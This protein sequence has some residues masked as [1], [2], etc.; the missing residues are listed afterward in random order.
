MS[1]PETQA[2][3][4]NPWV[5][6]M[7]PGDIGG[8]NLADE[9]RQGGLPIQIVT[10]SDSISQIRKPRAIIV[11][12]SANSETSE[13]IHTILKTKLQP[14]IPVLASNQSLPSGPWST[15]PVLLGKD[16]VR[17]ILEYLSHWETNSM[18][19]QNTMPRQSFSKS[20]SSTRVPSSAYSTKPA[21]KPMESKGSGSPARPIPPPPPPPVRRGFFAPQSLV[22]IVILLVVVGLVA[23]LIMVARTFLLGGSDVTNYSASVPGPTCDND[24]HW[25]Q[26]TGSQFTLACEKDGLVVTKPA[27]SH[28]YAEIIFEGQGSSRHNFPTSYRAKVNIDVIKGGSDA[29]IGLKVHSQQPT[30]GH[31]LEI[32]PDSRWFISRYDP[33]GN[34]TLLARGATNKPATHYTLEVTVD[35][36]II[37]MFIDGTK[38]IT[39]ADNTFNST[40]GIAL[41]AMQGQNQ[42]EDLAVKFSQFQFTRLDDPKLSASDAVATIT[43]QSSTQS[44]TPY[45]ASVPGSECDKGGAIWQMPIVLGNTAVVTCQTN[46]MQIMQDS[47]PNQASIVRFLG[48]NG[49]LPSNYKIEVTTD[50]SK[51]PSKGC[52][53]LY[54][55][56]GS[57]GYYITFICRDGSWN[58]DRVSLPGGEHTTLDSGYIGSK[59]T[60]KIALSAN[61]QTHTLSVDDK[62]LTSKKD[63]TIAETQFIGLGLDNSKGSVVFSDFTFTLL[64]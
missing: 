53:T 1:F 11:I 62:E 39:V 35:G 58:L 29:T 19:N 48:F 60:Y 6:V 46:G 44:H 3:Q 22:N 18:D 36:P 57:S 54:T 41:E 28:N 15:K 33:N 4:N 47:S 32:S 34:S 8:S 27:N 10:S 31:I 24:G 38:A 12:L 51:M 61:G 2:K 5:I 59:S 64:S 42:K 16:T 17:T 40:I 26:A 55:R 56:V 9:L 14:V 50:L 45:H 63:S 23:S 21:S 25:V 49:I 30:G 37:T 52:A 13:P 7:K 20:A 43:S